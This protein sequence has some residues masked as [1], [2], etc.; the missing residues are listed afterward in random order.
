MPEQWFARSDANK[1]GALTPAELGERS[2]PG[3]HQAGDEARGHRGGKLASLDQNND[4]KV[5]R[6]EVR[7]AA[8]RM[9]E[10]LDKNADG[11]LTSEELGRHAGRGHGKGRHGEGGKGADGKSTDAKPQ[12]I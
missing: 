11:S 7:N 2:G 6:D 10:R 4:G 9:L 8:A 12:A 1:D 5:E 3:K